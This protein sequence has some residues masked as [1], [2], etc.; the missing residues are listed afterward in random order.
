MAR[1]H[2]ELGGSPLF[3]DLMDIG[4]ANTSILNI[5]NYV[6]LEALSSSD[7]SLFKRTMRF[8]GGKRGALSGL[9]EIHLILLF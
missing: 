9:R 1:N 3:T 7:S 6:I 2:W 5:D 4:M 8:Y